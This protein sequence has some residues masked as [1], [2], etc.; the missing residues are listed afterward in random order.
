MSSYQIHYL[1]RQ[2]ALAC[3]MIAQCASDDEA[4]QLAIS[5]PGI[6]HRTFE[7]WRGEKLVHE[8]FNPH[9]AN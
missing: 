4:R 9:I 1:N 2:R 3:L 5:L 6:T 7:V 8:G